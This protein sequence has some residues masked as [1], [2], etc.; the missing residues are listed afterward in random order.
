MNKISKFITNNLYAFSLYTRQIA[1][2]IVLFVIAHYLSVYD[3]GLFTSYKSII[4]FCFMLANMEYA[5]YILVSS[6]VN[7]HE[8]KLKIALFLLNAIMIAFCIMF[9]SLFFK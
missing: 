5:N 4:T 2:T 6:K 9:F 3:Y 1:G 8:V 7:I